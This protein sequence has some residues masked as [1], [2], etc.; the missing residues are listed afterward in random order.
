MFQLRLQFTRRLQSSEVCAEE[1]V[2]VVEKDAMYFLSHF[3]LMCNNSLSVDFFHADG[4]G[5]NPQQ[6]AGNPAAASCALV[7]FQCLP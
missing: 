2:H 4:V 7:R 6:S 5:I 1:Y 3:F